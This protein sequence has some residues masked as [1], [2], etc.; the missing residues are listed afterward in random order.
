MINL[1]NL[2]TMAGIVLDERKKREIDPTLTV[3]RDCV[4]DSASKSDEE[5]YANKNSKEMLEYFDQMV[6]WYNQMSTISTDNVMRLIKLGSGVK[7]VL[8]KVK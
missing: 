8:D 3:L 1:H 6:G 2:I 7:K 5:E 4:L